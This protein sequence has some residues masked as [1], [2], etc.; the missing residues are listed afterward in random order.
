MK[1]LKTILITILIVFLG[2]LYLNR[3]SSIVE[4]K[5]DVFAQCINDSGAKFYGSYQCI[6]CKTQKDMFGSSEK[7]LPYIECGPL[8]GP[9]SLVCQ[10]AGVTGYPT[11]DFPDGERI[12]GSLSFDVLS[13][14]TNCPLPE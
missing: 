11:W 10:Q 13:K 4:G 2:Y 14:H 8:S 12:S 7:L 1:Y 6:H 3:G 9:Q 5:Y